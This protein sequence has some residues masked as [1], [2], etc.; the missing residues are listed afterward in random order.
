IT[1]YILPAPPDAPIV[2]MIAKEN[3]I[4]LFWNDRA[5]RSIDP[6]SRKQDFEGYRIYK[7]S[8]GFDLQNNQD[9][10][11]AMQL[12]A[13]FDK[14]G[15]QI[16]YDNGFGAI[17]LPQPIQF[18]GDTTRYHYFYE[19]KNVLNGWQHAVSVTAFDS[20]EPENDLE[21]LETSKLST[22]KRIFPGKPANRGFV[23]GEPFV[24]P[25]PYYASASWEGTAQPE[26][27]RKII[28]ANLPPNCEVRIYT[29]AGDLVKTF[30]HHESYQ[31]EDTKWFQ[32]YSNPKQNQ[33][34]GGEHAWD[35]L[36]SDTQ[37]IARGI[38]LFAVKD[39]DSGE[40]R[41]G[42]FVVIK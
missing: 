28:F 33:F 23:F 25:N 18:E 2:K 6:I 9:I 16:G 35:L 39:L 5:E 34:S 17:R 10:A 11:T 30:E 38:Y 21:S 14:P 29:V 12:V 42:K 36:S 26:Q 15:N 31:G 20:G 32:T 1:R 40:I 22:M 13:S 8:V 41:R 27:N 7:T 4:Q 19:F 24:Y 37:I 3:T